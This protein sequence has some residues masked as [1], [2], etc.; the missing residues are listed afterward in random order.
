MGKLVW[1]NEYQTIFIETE[2]AEVLY[3]FMDDF[4]RPLLFAMGYSE[5]A[6]ESWIID[7]AAVIENDNK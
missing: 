7:E 6:V 5:K 3:R 1:K 2:D 4:V